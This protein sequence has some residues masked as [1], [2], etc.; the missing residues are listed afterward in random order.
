VFTPIELDKPRK[1][2]FNIQDC[3]DMEALLGMSLGQVA[4]RLGTINVQVICGA[5]WAG[6]KHEDDALTVPAVK[7]ILEAYCEK[8]DIR[9]VAN[10]LDKAISN[11]TP[12]KNVI[13]GNGKPKAKN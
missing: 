7:D 6:L 1:L 5:L 8:G 12:L 2:R 3:C 9:L 11:S 13:V 10:A 4:N